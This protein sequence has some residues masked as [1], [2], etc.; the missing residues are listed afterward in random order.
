MGET[1]RIVFSAFRSGS[2]PMLLSWNRFRDAVA[3]ANAPG[4]GASAAGSTASVSSASGSPESVA[5][6]GIWRL[7]A[8]NN[9]ELARS[10]HVYPSL[11]AARTHVAQLR[12]RA[13][14]LVL[15]PVAGPALGRRG[16]YL[17]LGGTVVL[18]CGRWYGAASSST[19]AAHA[20]LAALALAE[21]P[22][23]PRFVTTGRR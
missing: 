4:S 10:A 14:E 7:L 19:E 22:A 23:A 15:T 3:P 8:T 18:T 21:I 20:A 9:R 6:A 16:W 11:A 12:E 1:P 2:D 13:D 5:G 17:S